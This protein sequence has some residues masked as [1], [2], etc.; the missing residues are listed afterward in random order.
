MRLKYTVLVSAL[1]VAVSAWPVA[2][3]VV[4]NEILP[5]PGS[6]YD[7]AEFVELHNTTAA[8]VSIAG[9]VLTG[10]EYS[11]TCGGEDHQQFP[12]GATIPANG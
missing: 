7:G 5:N 4:I 9:W 1:L 3:Q 8:P 2:A 11:G 12:A 6:Y 10:T